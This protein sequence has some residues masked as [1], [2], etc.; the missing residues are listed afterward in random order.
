MARPHGLRAAPPQTWRDHPSRPCP[1]SV[2]P[3]PRAS[4]RG[5]EPQ[6][7][8]AGPTACLPFCGRAGSYPAWAP[9]L[10]VPGPGFWGTGSW[11]AP[12]ALAAPSPALRG[13]DAG[14]CS[15]R[16]S[17]GFGQGSPASSGSPP[18]PIPGQGEAGRDRACGY[19]E[20][21]RGASLREGQGGLPG[22]GGAPQGPRHTCP[23]GSTSRSHPCP[24]VGHFSA[25]GALEPRDLAAPWAGGAAGTALRPP[26]TPNPPWATPAS[27]PR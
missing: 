6:G 23:S 13:C 15:D 20:P 4:S 8:R 25:P 16:S 2:L 26:L 18:P 1:A 17:G 5:G 3:A 9:A 10:A 22:G 19:L 21:L 12:P 24:R 11:A 7:R 27:G 14:G